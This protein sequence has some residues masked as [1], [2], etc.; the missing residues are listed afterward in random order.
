[1]SRKWG[2]DRS[3]ASERLIICW[4]PTGVAFVAP[5][6]KLCPSH[7]Q[8]LQRL[9][10][11]RFECVDLRDRLRLQGCALRSITEGLLT[12]IYLLHRSSQL[13]LQHGEVVGAHAGDHTRITCSTERAKKGW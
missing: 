10:E 9:R 2:F 6:A 8:L 5:V 3:R 1:M 12:L 11:L 7:A 4:R 13:T